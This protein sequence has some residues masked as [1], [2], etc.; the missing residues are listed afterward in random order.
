[1]FGDSGHGI[2]MLIAASCFLIF[3]KKLI[4]AKIKDEIFNTFFG[5]RYV[6]FLMSLFSIY[7]GLLYNDIYSKS[8]NIFG[9]QWRTPLALK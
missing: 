7:T 2:I 4:A 5:G 1:M 9:S 6:V 3:E 8:L